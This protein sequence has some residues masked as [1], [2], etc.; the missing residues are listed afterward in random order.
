MTH[1]LL[2]HLR[3]LTLALTLCSSLPAIS[4]SI[5]VY[6]KD[7]GRTDFQTKDIESIVFTD[8]DPLPLNQP[9]DVK[10]VDLGLSVKWASCNLGATKET[11]TGAYFAWGETAEKAVY[12]WDTYFDADCTATDALICGSPQDAAYEAWG[13]PW[14][15]PTLAEMQELCERCTWTWQ[16]KN[17]AVGCLVTGPNGASIFLPAAGVKQGN[18]TYLPTTF[19]AYMTGTR[20]AANRYYA[21][22]LVFY[23]DASHWIDTNLRDYG[24]VL[25][26]VRR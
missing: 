17:G 5:A 13:G 10:A 20:D 21:R 4:Q 16:T 25:R 18:E 2:I 7:G 19:G 22:S 12:D 6:A 23:K 11:E 3:L 26:P 15:L 1:H 9:S 14:R 24:Q 8:A